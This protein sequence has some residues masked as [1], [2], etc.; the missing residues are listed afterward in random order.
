MTALVSVIMPVYNAEKYVGKAI[1]SVLVQSYQ[2]W[3]L[4]IINDGST[5]ASISIISS[6]KNKRIRLLSQENKGVSAAR[7]VG[8]SVMKGDFFCFLDA[9]DQLPPDSLKSRMQVFLH[10]PKI[11]YVDGM[12]E[13]RDMDLKET[14][15]WFMPSLK[16]K[17]PLL[18]LIKLTGRSFFGPSWMIRRLPGE[19]YKFKEGLSHAE[20][21]LFYMELARSGGEYAFVTEVVYV[22]RDSPGSAMKNLEGLEKGYQQVFCE[23]RNWPEIPLINLLVFQCKVKKIMFLSYLH[24]GKCL[25]ALKALL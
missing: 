9:D 21:L 15:G 18:D 6:N 7:N 24:A 8:L 16:K 23:I 2:F 3:E 12:V 22:Y 4:I 20:D 25:K 10:D 13:K 11:Y 17:N 14:I 19:S 5:D 1:Q